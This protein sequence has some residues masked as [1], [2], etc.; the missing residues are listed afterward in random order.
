[1]E[2]T[3]EGIVPR[4]AL[5]SP[6]KLRLLSLRQKRPIR[7]AFLPKDSTNRPKPPRYVAVNAFRPVSSMTG[8]G[9][10]APADRLPLGPLDP[11]GRIL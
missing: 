8:K 6:K 4:F 3:S 2:T 11:G 9:E 7:E 1:M 5:Q 10:W